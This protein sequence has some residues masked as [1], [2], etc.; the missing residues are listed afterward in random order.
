MRL[1]MSCVTQWRIHSWLL[2]YL[3]TMG[4]RPHSDLHWLD[5]S[6]LRVLRIAHVFGVWTNDAAH[7]MIFV[8]LSFLLFHL[9]SRLRV[10]RS[11]LAMYYIK[12]FGRGP[13]YYYSC[14]KIRAS[15]VA[16]LHLTANHIWE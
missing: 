15:G 5:R 4:Y 7:E 12:P 2:Y 13:V 16:N 1:I 3:S 8:W 6:G 9:S 10:G 11:S 14:I